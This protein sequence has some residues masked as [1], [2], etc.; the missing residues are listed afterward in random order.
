MRHIFIAA[1]FAFMGCTSAPT[2]T[3]EPTT[4]TLTGAIT[5]ADHQT[6]RELPFI[7]PAGTHSIT[8]DFSYDREN[9]TVIDLGLRDTHG[10]LGC[11]ACC[12]TPI[13]ISDRDG[14]LSYKP[15]PMQPGTWYLVLEVPNTRDGKSSPYKTTTAFSSQ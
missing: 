7:V 2:P 8:I 11:S 10:Q 9:R 14:M 3:F 4:I 13:E 6:Y 1:A 5:R 15:A 12:K